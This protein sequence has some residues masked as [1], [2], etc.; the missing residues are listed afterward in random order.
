MVI[1][2]VLTS[3][4]AKLLICFSMYM[5]INSFIN[6][7]LLTILIV[8]PICSKI[9]F[10]KRVSNSFLYFYPSTNLTMAVKNNK[11]KQYDYIHEKQIIKELFRKEF[12]EAI[13]NS[14]GKLKFNSHRWVIDNVVND[15]KIASVYDIN[16]KKSKYPGYI[17]TEILM[18]V[19]LRW[20]LTLSKE[21]LN[22]FY[23][24][25]FA[26]REEFLIELIKKQ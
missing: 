19:S 4:T 21:D 16:F 9:I 23:K 11:Y 8:I 20:I 5:F 1:K 3:I 25:C 26:K 2:I 22:S 12:I 7:G 14:G 10:C 15:N 13:L 24:M 6:L 18:M 17:I